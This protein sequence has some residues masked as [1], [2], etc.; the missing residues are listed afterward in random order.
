MKRAVPIMLLLFILC[1][2]LP[3]GIRPLMIPDE[4]RYAE[5]PREMIR[6][7]DWIVPRLDG[8]RYFEKPVLGYWIEAGAQSLFG[9]NR[10][11]VRLPVAVAAALTAFI[12][13]LL[14][15]RF[16][17]ETSTAHLTV[18]I[19]LTF[20]EVFILG[21]FNVL[22]GFLNLFL[23]GAMVSFFF[24]NR[25]PE[26]IKERF[27][28]A[29]FGVFCGLSFL[30]KGF[31]AF[32][33]PGVVVIPYMIWTGETRKLLRTAWLPIVSALIV[34]LPWS[35][36]VWRRAPD[37]WRYFFWVQHIQRFFSSGNSQHPQPFW[38][39]LPVLAAGMLPWTP[40]FPAI[41]SGL[42]KLRPFSHLTKFAL[43]WFAFPFILLSASHGKLITYILPCYP[44]L[45]ILTAAGLTAYLRQSSGKAFSVGTRVAAGIAGLLAMT[46]FLS[47]WAWVP[48][49]PGHGT[50]AWK[51]AAA[52]LALFGA[53]GL[54]F[55]SPRPERQQRR[56]A[57]FGLGGVL[58]LGSIHLA[59]PDR[60]L[61][62][63]SPGPFLR[64]HADEA[65]DRTMIVSEGGLVPAIC[66]SYERDD[67]LLLK[68]E[69]GEFKY[70][71]A[72]PDAEDHV[73]PLKRLGE[74]IRKNPRS[75][76]ILLI[77]RTHLYKVWKRSLPEPLAL[78]EDRT[79]SFVIA[80][81]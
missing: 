11:A 31:L 52:C 37:F 30:A 67:V 7:G 70:G 21:I 47:R 8:L 68:D 36:L 77:G 79:G 15:R 45:A 46:L 28:L 33:I 16:T 17:S 39:F 69:A 60:V 27:F 3:L 5:I 81:F 64:E 41:I 34:V 12:L 53:A 73:I 61:L 29:L 58:F 40:I 6:T 65:G 14:V 20:I 2:I 72:Y 43:C 49:A 80:R 22:D 62:S 18:I 26:P 24:A 66:W 59:V 38:F 44:P 10:F 51:W 56:L 1:Y 71:I 4:T 48:G 54:F 19:Y 50:E 75:G 9:R 57:L 63:R 78:H 32:A 23:T 42:K 35:L 74:L 13:F 76:R 55:L 25:E